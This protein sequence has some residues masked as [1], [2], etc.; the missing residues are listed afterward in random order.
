MNVIERMESINADKRIADF[1][2]K[3][4]QPYDFKVN[5]AFTRVKEFVEECGKLDL[6]VH[7]PEIYGTI[8]RKS[9]G[10]LFTTGAQRTGCSF[11]GFGILLEHRH[12]RFD[13]LYD[14]NPKEWYFWMY[15][16]GWGHV[17]DYIGVEWRHDIDQMSLFDLER[18]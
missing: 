8:E 18:I 12:H 10:T 1:R 17:L 11:C 7:V 5:Y 13:M 16:Q 6:N 9:D 4:K 15:N 14:R 3:M 2:V